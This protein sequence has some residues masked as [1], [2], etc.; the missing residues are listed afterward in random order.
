MPLTLGRKSGQTIVIGENIVVTVEGRGKI[1]VHVAAPPEV[2]I[3]RGELCEPAENV[4][5]SNAIES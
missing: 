1:R 5:E 2:K 4:V 3:R